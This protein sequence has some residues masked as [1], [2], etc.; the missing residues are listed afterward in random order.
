MRA[1]VATGPATSNAT[2]PTTL[3][4]TVWLD[5]GGDISSPEQ[6]AAP[7]ATS[8]QGQIVWL[9]SCP[10]DNGAAV[11]AFDFQWRVSGGSWSVSTVVAHGYYLLTGLVNGSTYQARVRATNSAGTS[12]WSASGTGS[13]SALMPGRV[14]GVVATAGDTLVALQWLEPEANGSPIQ[15]YDVEWRSG[16]QSFSSSR[17]VTSAVTNRV[18]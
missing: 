11:T 14:T 9:W 4:Q 5:V 15:S 18:M 6:P 1:S 8:G 16:S 10:K 17:R 3:G 2:D 7:A 12:T 13:P